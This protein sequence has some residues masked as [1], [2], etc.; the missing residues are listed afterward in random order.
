MQLIMLL[1]AVVTAIYLAKSKRKTS[2]VLT[3][4][5]KV[6]SV[7]GLLINHVLALPAFQLFINAM[8]CNDDDNL[9]GGIQCYQGIY[10]FHLVMGIIG[11]ITFFSVSIL[12]CLLYNE[13][14]PYSKIPFASPQSKLNLG[15]ILLKIVIPLYFTLDY[16]VTKDFLWDSLM[17]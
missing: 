8:I 17:F 5:L 3:Y 6:L 14:N 13:L 15:K 4:S 16:K 12:F 1:L 9:H 2:T 7:Y 11:F 10:F